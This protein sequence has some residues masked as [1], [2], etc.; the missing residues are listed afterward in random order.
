MSA[1]KNV[2]DDVVG[3]IARCND[4]AQTNVEVYA[5]TA[6]EDDKSESRELVN[7][8]LLEY[9]KFKDCLLFPRV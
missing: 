7:G 6:L 1:L 5:R 9:R 8:V 3:R 4:I 2:A